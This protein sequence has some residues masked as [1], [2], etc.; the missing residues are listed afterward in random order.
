MPSSV[1]YRF[2][3]DKSEMTVLGLPDSE[4]DKTYYVDVIATRNGIST[5]K[6][7]G[8]YRITNS[9]EKPII[10]IRKYNP[11]T[12]NFELV[13]KDYMSD[14]NTEPVNRRAG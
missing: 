10:K 6:A 1:T 9:P 8:D 4:L 5:S 2:N 11:N 14:N 12:N 7:S 3:S 13:A